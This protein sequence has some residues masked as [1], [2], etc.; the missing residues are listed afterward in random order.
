MKRARMM[1]PPAAGAL[2]ALGLA[3]CDAP[4]APCGLELCDIRTAP[5]QE[6]TALAT[7]CLRG[8]AALRVPVTVVGRATVRREAEEE[9]ARSSSPEERARFARRSA[10]LGLLGLAPADLSPEAAARRTADWIGA[11]YSPQEKAITVVDD[12]EPRR[13]P[14]AVA[15]LVHEYVH[16]LQDRDQGFAELDG[17]F[18]RDFDGALASG[19]VIEGEATFVQDLAL[20]GLFDVDE[21][22]VSWPQIF[23]GWQTRSRAAALTS[24]VPVLLA[25]A[26]FRYPFGTALVERRFRE[27]GWAGVEAL[28]RDP[29]RATR[30]VLL[31]QG[32]PFEADDVQDRAVPDLPARFTLVER[33]RLGGWIFDLFLRRL[34]LDRQAE[35]ALP[36]LRGDSLAILEDAETR[37]TALTWRLRFEDDRTPAL[38]EGALPRTRPWRAWSEGRDLV[39]A[40][41][42][43]RSVLELFDRGLA[44][45]PA[46]AKASDPGGAPAPAG[47]P[48]RC[49]PPPRR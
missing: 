40:A 27:A 8:V 46:P 26:H 25:P 13:S 11:W 49:L 2:V 24:P 30:Q 45:K 34:G 43:D 16:A 21:R 15:L 18:G 35:A 19:A 4:S 39:L 10:G 32:G 1:M 12:G 17:T 3:A 23:R 6:A 9:A 41:S 33:D 37:A 20:L 44:F 22:E 38:L 48:V 28:R 29:P 7:A 42:T 14:Y 5:C 47:A 31:G 36:A